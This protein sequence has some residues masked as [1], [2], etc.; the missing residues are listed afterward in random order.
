MP[1]SDATVKSFSG[2]FNFTL[3]LG[4]KGF[5]EMDMAL[6]KHLLFNKKPLAFVRTQCDSAINGI[7]DAEYDKVIIETAKICKL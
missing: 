6:L 1:K 3:M 2:H 4:E 5:N 7:L